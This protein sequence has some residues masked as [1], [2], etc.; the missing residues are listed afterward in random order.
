VSSTDT[1]RLVRGLVGG[2]PAASVALVEA[3]R[4]STDPVV[5]A[6]AALLTGHAPELL[7]R[8]YELA[9]D[10]GTR[11]IVGVV[12]AHVSRDFGRVDTLAREHLVD[13]P[14]SVL[15]AWIA[16]QAR[17]AAGTPDPLEMT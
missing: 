6:A 3:A 4:T 10:T 17:S 7:T 11:Q 2:A 9:Q 12:A 14:D 13:H 15:V 5:L 16:A 1:D 8:A